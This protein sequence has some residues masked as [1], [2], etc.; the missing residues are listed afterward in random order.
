M[1]TLLGFP[2]LQTRTSALGTFL[3]PET[4]IRLTVARQIAPLLIGV[5]RDFNREVEPLKPGQCG[6]WNPRKIR[7]SEKWSEHAFGLAIDLNWLLHQQ[8][9]RNTFTSK[10]RD[11]IHEILGRYAYKGTRVLR[12]G[13]DYSTTPDDMHF[14]VVAARATAL[15]AVKA[16]QKPKTPVPATGP[17]PGSRTLRE[18][19]AGSDVAFLQRWVGVEPDTGRFDHATTIRVRRYQSIVGLPV[20]GIA[21]PRT[22]AKILGR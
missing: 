11:K 16:L 12:W 7:G 5:A 21:G 4:T 10:Q 2:L 3:V 13:G 17:K 14:E 15:A 6:G 1:T 9:R 22:W 20:D 19:M 8:G 18:G